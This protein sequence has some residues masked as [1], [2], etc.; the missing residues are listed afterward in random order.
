MKKS[1][2]APGYLFLKASKERT[3][4]LLTKSAIVPAFIQSGLEFAKQNYLLTS[5]AIGN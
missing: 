1:S 3:A 5:Q 4:D 2:R